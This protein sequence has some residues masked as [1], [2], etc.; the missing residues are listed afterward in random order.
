MTRLQQEQK[1]LQEEKGAL[2]GR[3]QQSL[4]HVADT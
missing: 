1:K 4:S 3:L 2:Q